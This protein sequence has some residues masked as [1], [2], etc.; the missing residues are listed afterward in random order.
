MFAENAGMR[1]PPSSPRRSWLAPAIL[2]LGSFVAVPVLAAAPRDPQVAAAVF[3]PWWTPS[4]ALAAADDAGH[5]LAV[6]RAS[7]IVI[8]RSTDGDVAPR[9]HASGALLVLDP[10]AA[11]PCAG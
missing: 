11:G 8:V 5:I 4:K 9:L 6:G 1:I 3:P 2:A 7:F 10:Q